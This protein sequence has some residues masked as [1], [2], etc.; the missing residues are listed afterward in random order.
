MDPLAIEIGLGLVRY[1]EGG[2]S[3]PLLRRISSIRRQLAAELGYVLPPVRVTDNLTLKSREYVVS[4]KG[5]E[6]ARN[7]LPAGCDLAIRA[8]ADGP[9][10]EGTVVTDPAFGLPAVWIPAE[11]RDEA[12]QKGYTVAD[13]LGVIGTQLSEIVRRH[14]HEL[15]SRQDAKRFLDRVGEEHPKTVEGSGAQTAPAFRRSAGAPESL[16]P[17]VSIR[18]GA[19]ILEALSEGGQN[20]RNVILLTEYVR[21]AIRRIL[22]QPYLNSDADLPIY[23]VAPALERSLEERVEH[24]ELASHLNLDITAMNQVLEAFQC[25]LQGKDVSAAALVTPGCRPFVRQITEASF[26][27]LAI[28]SHNEIPGGVRLVSLG[29]I[30]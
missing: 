8:Q 9:E 22:V 16:A 23:F 26:P 12:R 27:N 28:L 17:R 2:A 3:S 15:F 14:A 18:D 11:R 25:S 1:V 21:Q 6:I 4:L 29:T 10:L 19:T 5:A 7:F 30:E 20:S 24:G 13:A